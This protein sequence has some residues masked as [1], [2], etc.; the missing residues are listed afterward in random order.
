MPKRNNYNMQYNKQQSTTTA[1][2]NDITIAWTTTTVDD[3]SRRDGG[4]HNLRLCKSSSPWISILVMRFTLR[5]EK[6]VKLNIV[7]LT[8]W[9][10]DFTHNVNNSRDLGILKMGKMKTISDDLFDSVMVN[11]K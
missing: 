5:L 10:G 11:D 8:G 2:L 4:K 9:A 3:D 7:A 1:W 6:N